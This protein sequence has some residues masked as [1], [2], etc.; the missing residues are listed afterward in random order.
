M[1]PFGSGAASGAKQAYP[2]HL[3][4]S[5]RGF[6]AAHETTGV[7]QPSAVV[8]GCTS[9]LIVRRATS[10]SL[11]SPAMSSAQ[12]TE[13]ALGSGRSFMPIWRCH[14]PRSLRRCGRFAG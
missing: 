5:F 1:K 8:V 2:I 4:L 7:E 11:A 6:R 3:I 13:D 12:A 9:S 10:L 14:C